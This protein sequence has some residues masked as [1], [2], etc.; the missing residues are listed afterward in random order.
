MTPWVRGLGT[1]GSRGGWSPAG[2][3]PRAC[4][5]NRLKRPPVC[6]GLGQWLGA[7]NRRTGR[8]RGSNRCCLPPGGAGSG[9]TT[10]RWPTR[11]CPGCAPACPG[12]TCPNGTGRGRPRTSGCEWTLDG[13]WQK[14]LDE[15]IAS[16]DGP[17]RNR[18]PSWPTRPIPIPRPAPHCGR[19]GSGSPVPSATT[20][21]PAAPPR[22]AR[23][24]ARRISPRR[25][26]AGA[27]SSSA[28]S[29]DPGTS[30]AWP[31]AFAKRVAYYRSEPVIAATI[32]GFDD[33]QDRP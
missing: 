27:T 26:T 21:R 19:A 5:A 11:S 3:A 24:A 23:A 18:R 25:N 8:G 6:A 28:V 14:I 12:G 32:S 30:A 16:G 4:P 22:A 7:V 1:T 15:A 10:G 2:D 17:G 13:T 29:T 31:P 20:R 33:S 9:G